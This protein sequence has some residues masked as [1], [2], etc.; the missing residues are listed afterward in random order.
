[1]YS[2]LGREIWSIRRR[3]ISVF[4]VWRTARAA[5][6]RA[7]ITVELAITSQPIAR[8]VSRVEVCCVS[9]R[10]IKDI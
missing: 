4:S 2:V 9:S 10:Q 8:T 6:I 5:I 7:V 1:V 3:R